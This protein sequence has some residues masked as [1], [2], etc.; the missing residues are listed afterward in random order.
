MGSAP[1]EE[2]GETAELC[3]REHTEKGLVSMQQG[4]HLQ[5]RDRALPR[6]RLRDPLIT[7]FQPPEPEP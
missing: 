6:P 2:E 5:A 7:D 1:L 4:G 3:P